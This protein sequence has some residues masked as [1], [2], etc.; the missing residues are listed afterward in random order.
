MTLQRKQWGYAKEM[1]HYNAD[2][3]WSRLAYAIKNN[4]NMLTNS[5]PLSDGSIHPVDVESLLAVGRRIRESG[6]PLPADAIT[7]DSW[8]APKKNENTAIAG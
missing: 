3:I 4:C 2:E 5:G 7:P 6:W 8:T 1:E